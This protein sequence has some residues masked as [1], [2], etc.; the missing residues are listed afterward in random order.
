M[1]AQSVSRVEIEDVMRRL[2]AAMVVSTSVQT[3]QT[4]T[5]PYLLA[6]VFL[7]LRFRRRTL[8][9]LHLALI[10]DYCE[11]VSG[12]AIDRQGDLQRITLDW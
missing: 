2:F 3:M 6:L 11:S 7:L 12:C 10:F 1:R 4:I 9:F 5:S 8:F